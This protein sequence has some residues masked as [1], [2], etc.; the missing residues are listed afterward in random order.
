M[1][2]EEMYIERYLFHSVQWERTFSST[3]IFSFSVLKA[4]SLGSQSHVYIIKYLLAGP[5]GSVCHLENRTLLRYIRIRGG[6]NAYPWKSI[7]NR[8]EQQQES[9]KFFGQC[10]HVPF[11]LVSSSIFGET[12]RLVLSTCV[13]SVQFVQSLTRLQ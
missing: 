5:F 2:L 13:Y 12:S 9:N 7:W 6:I 4:S 8:D 10:Q 3:F 11:K 1:W